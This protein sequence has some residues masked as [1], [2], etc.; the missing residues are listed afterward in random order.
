MMDK[1]KKKRE[2]VESLNCDADCSHCQAFEM[3][4]EIECAS[5]EI[6]TGTKLGLASI[7]TFIIPLIGAISGAYFT[8]QSH[9]LQL[10]GAL[11]GFFIGLVISMGVSRYL[12]QN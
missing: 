4:S 3:N 8:S 6:L 2:F 5:P 10:V 1:K 7:L 11:A 12:T 9:T